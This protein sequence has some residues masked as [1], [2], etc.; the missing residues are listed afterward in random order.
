MHKFYKIAK[1]GSTFEELRDSFDFAYSM[2][3]DGASSES[4]YLN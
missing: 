4:R 3:N 2:I 1:L